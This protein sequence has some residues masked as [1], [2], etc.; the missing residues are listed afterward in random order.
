MAVQI[1][2]VCEHLL[3]F[4]PVRELNPPGM[5]VARSLTKILQGGCRC[6][7]K[8]SPS[9]VLVGQ[10]SM[11]RI[12]NPRQRTTANVPHGCLQSLEF[13]NSNAAFFSAAADK[14]FVCRTGFASGV[15]LTDLFCRTLVCGYA[16]KCVHVWKLGNRNKRAIEFNA[17]CGLKASQELKN[18]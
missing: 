16:N 15:R 2:R 17:A 10:D 8:F 9:P 3:A 14:C 5:S 1:A 7:K 11:R 4:N 13:F 6:M 12:W 18:R